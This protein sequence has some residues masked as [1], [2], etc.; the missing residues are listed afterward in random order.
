MFN[1]ERQANGTQ[2]IVAS[3]AQKLTAEQQ[4]RDA[5]ETHRH[6]VFSVSYYMTSNEVEAEAIL[7]G[8]FVQAFK[9][10]PKPDGDDVD[11]ALLAELEQRFT[12][13]HA[14]HATPDSA[15]QMERGQVRR[16]DLEEAVAMLPARERLIFLLRDVEGYA[17][18]K[19]AALLR[20]D[21]LEVQKT[22]ISAR[23]R[24]RNELGRLRML[25]QEQADTQ[26]ADIEEA[27]AAS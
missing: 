3:E 2:G 15:V 13:S 6:R 20:C 7:T 12:L 19:I 5:F 23:I 25:A 8:T 10:A 14:P 4:Q 16:T 1:F 11:K 22:L 26:E 18:L 21:D 24:M 17:A 27:T 9:A